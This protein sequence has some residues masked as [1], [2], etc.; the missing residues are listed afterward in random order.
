MTRV[1]ITRAQPGADA[2][3]ARVRDLGMQPLVEPLLEVRPLPSG[4][5]DL[6]GVGAL[7][8]TSANAVRAFVPHCAARGLPVFVVGG[9]T[10]AA[11]RDAGF[12]DVRSA[13]G[14][15]RLLGELILSQRHALAGA[16]LHPSAVEPAGDLVGALE[17]AGVE[18]ARLALYETVM[19]AP[20]PTLLEALPG[21]RFVLLHSPRGARALAGVLD[22]FS[23]PDLTALCLS[24]AAAAPLTA[25][26]LAVV[27]SA[28][29]PREDA[30][31][32]LL[33]AWARSG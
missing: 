21:V 25:A 20:A 13:D 30:L 24:P 27:A 12:D 4:P 5:L 2:T 19:R 7:A 33:D 26:G 17:A 29:A 6:A 14:D 32:E 11:A 16:V 8:F 10:A 28:E 1:W 9:A 3:A 18:A 31:M 22:R 15:V 23:A